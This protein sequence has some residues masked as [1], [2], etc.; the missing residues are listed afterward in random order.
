MDYLLVAV[1]LLGFI[2]AGRKIWWAWYVNI[3][4]QFLWFAYAIISQQ[5]GFILGAIVYTIVFTGNAIK[6]TKEHKA[7]PKE[8]P[9]IPEEL[10]GIGGCVF[11]KGH[12]SLHTWQV[13]T[14]ENNV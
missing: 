11:L 2:L 3:A 5:Y 9:D 8:V 12:N 6:W 7:K 13:S 14:K 4:C 10:C 1:G